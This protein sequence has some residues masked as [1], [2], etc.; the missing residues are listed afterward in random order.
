MQP[1]PGTE[2]TLESLRDAA[3]GNL[4]GYKL[5]RR[6][7]LVDRVERSPAGKPDQRWAAAVA[8]AA[9]TTTG[10]PPS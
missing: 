4:A 5:P 8:A 2:P 7:V 10:T 6:V 1:R 9:A 3:R